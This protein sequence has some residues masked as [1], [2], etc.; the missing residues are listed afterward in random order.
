MPIIVRIKRL[1]QEEC[2]DLETS[3]GYTDLSHNT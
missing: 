1:R 2:P 3:L